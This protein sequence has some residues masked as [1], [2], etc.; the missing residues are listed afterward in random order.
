MNGQNQTKKPGWFR[1]LIL[2]LFTV[3]QLAVILITA[4]VAGALVFGITSKLS[5]K[6]EAVKLGFEDIG[7]L[8]T[9]A[10]FCEEVSVTEADRELFGISIPFTQS[11][12]IYSYNVE[13]KAG[14]DFG[15]ITYTVDEE[16]KVIEVQLPPVEVLS[17][18]IDPTSFKLYHED[19][20]IFRQI[21]LEENNAALVQLEQQAEE[22][23]VANGLLE[24]ARTNGET[25]L[26]SFFHQVYSPEEYTI[27]YTD[28]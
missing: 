17:R 28:K 4:L 27:V 22:T 2:S 26:S 23:A 19:E 14:F 24:E 18:S 1:T 6:S 21:S 20:S 3:K 15:E 11:K 25:I 9:Q 16:N 5:S 10:A 7:E 13:I 12:Y 8:A